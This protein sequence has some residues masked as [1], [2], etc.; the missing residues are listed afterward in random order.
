MEKYYVPEISEFHVG[1]EFEYLIEKHDKWQISHLSNLSGID[2]FVK[3]NSVRVKHLDHEDIKECGWEYKGD[4]EFRLKEFILIDCQ[5]IIP[6]GIEI[7]FFHPD[8]KQQSKL[9]AAKILNR[10]ELRFQMDRLGIKK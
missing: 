9:F 8:Y 7:R 5:H 3:N 4:N 10:S 1:F 2:V 6:N